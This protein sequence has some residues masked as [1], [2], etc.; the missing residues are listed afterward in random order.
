[1]NLEAT[2][3][4]YDEQYRLGNALISDEEF[5]KLE[6]NLKAVHPDCDYFNKQLVLPSLV[7]DEIADFISDLS[8]DI[9]VMIQPKIDGCAVAVE[10]KNGKITK[11]ITRKGKDITEKM[12]R[13]STVPLRVPIKS[14]LMVRGELYAEDE[15]PSVSQRIAAGY[16]RSKSLD[17]NPNLKFSAFEI[18]N[19]ELDQYDALQYLR[20]KLGFNT[21]T[22]SLTEIT[23]IETYRR[24]WLNNNL[25]TG[26]PTDGIVV[27][28]NSR[29]LQ[30]ER[31]KN[32][33]EWQIAI[34]E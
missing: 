3:N 9:K 7:K 11:A 13:I 6:R 17:P 21:V 8:P 18:M 28:L 1:M 20:L 10:Y 29:K 5:N 15:T 24:N 31:E 14:T 4:Y 27:K 32:C 34:K 33:R 16:L 19:C 23:H 2:I 25:Y 26:Y 12:I 22:W 30:L